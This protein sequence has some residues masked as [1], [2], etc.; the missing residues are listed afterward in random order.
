M[1]ARAAIRL[2]CSQCRK[3]LRAI[4]P[5]HQMF[6]GDVPEHDCPAGDEMP[7]KKGVSPKTMSENIETEVAAG[8]PQKQAV[9]IGYSMQRRSGGKRG[10][11]GK[12]K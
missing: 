12:K 9:A 8:K 1:S 5:L 11:K 2:L 3:V 6:A 10:G 4:R 7:L